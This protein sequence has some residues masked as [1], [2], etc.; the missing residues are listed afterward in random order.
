M[1]PPLFDKLSQLWRRLLFYLRR[2]Q[3]DRELEEEMR[4]HLEMKAEENLAASVSTEEARYAAQ[5]Q[6]GNQTLLQ[7][8]SR[9]MW[10]IRSIETLFQDLRYGIRLLIKHKG[11]TTVAALSLGLGIGA[12]TA[13]FS[14]IN[15]ALLRTLPVPNP[16]RLV[17]LTVAGHRGVS[18]SFSYPLYEQFRD[19][20]QSFSGVFASGGGSRLRMVVS[21]PMGGGQTESVQAEKVSGNFF[22]ALGVTAIRGRALTDDDDRPGSPRPVAVISYGYWQRR[23]G[24]DPAAVGKT[25]ALNDV[26]FTI[27]GIT[28]PGF[29]GFEVGKS[30]DLWWPL[31]MTPQLY[32]G[33]QSLNQPGSEWLRLMGRLRPDRGQA[34]ALA[35][36][37]VIFQQALADRAQARA[38]RLGSVWTDAERRDFLNRRIALRSGSVGW[39]ELRRQFRQPLLILMAV[40]G[41]VLLIACANVANL[42][43]A[44]A[45]TR[46]KEI[47]MRLALGASRLRLVR[48][49]LTESALLA[50]IG[51]ALG[52]IFAYWSA[53]LLLDYLPGHETLSLDLDLDARV[54]GFTMTVS[55]ITGVLFGLA[56]ALRATRLDLTSALKEQAGGARIGQSR[57][58]LDKILVVSQVALSL[59]LLIGAGLFTRSLQ[60]LKGLDMG[61]DRENV[62]LFSLDLG[63]GYDAARRTDLY[64]R[65]LERLET[66]PGTRTA[67]LSSFGLL[68][69]NNWSDKV[70]AQGYTPRPDEDLICYGQIIGSR[71]FETMSIPLLLGRDFGSEDDQPGESNANRS[72]VGSA[73]EQANRRASPAAPQPTRRVAIINQAMARD[74][75]SNE[76]PIGKRF[77][78]IGQKDQPIE[79]V[80][81]VKD[82]K[83]RTLRER[84]PRIFYLPFFQQPSNSDTTFALR[85]F[86]QPVGLAETIRRAAQEIDPKLQVIG[87]RMMNDVVDRTLTQERFVAQLAGFFSL[88]ALLLAAIG[89]YGMMSYAVNRRISE[90]GIRIALGAQAGDVVRLVMRET[91]LLVAIGIVI[92]IGAAIAF[93]RLISSLLFGL[94]PTDPLTIALASLLMIASATLAGFLPARRACRVDP[95]IALRYE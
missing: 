55:L 54:L 27:I 40:V 92:G 78:I 50:M 42:L 22:S 57:L 25:I 2:D 30:P 4:F 33:N 59:F 20:T 75:F 70:I 7:E 71:F 19:R 69:N 29:F 87:M 64:R 38:A 47:T 32:P 94:T 23:F 13:I 85:T 14:L 79:I 77:S 53:R 11:F 62:V 6:F 34:Q 10:V 80:G 60:N 24:L 76:N 39:T 61:F 81:V 73:P 31:Q 67:S 74:F 52:L 26:A 35:E 68:S 1:I 66:L 51:G 72:T 17:F 91:M 45:A 56:P 95:M 49:L 18:E 84:T 21:E 93:T 58:P 28:P 9:D 12:N 44:R 41:L 82:A 8:V 46:Q 83:Y 88:F 86:I 48:Q 89:L 90:I 36:L 43:L 37:E 15:A 16:E 65:L 3:F 63:T 5:R